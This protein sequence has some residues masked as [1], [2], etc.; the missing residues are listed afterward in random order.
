M[1][2]EV[3]VLPHYALRLVTVAVADKQN[4]SHGLIRPPKATFCRDLSSGK[5][6]HFCRKSGP[7][8]QIA[9]MDGSQMVVEN[10]KVYYHVRSFSDH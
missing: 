9:A 3:R 7:T 8:R 6:V 4:L 5:N 1:P 2:H 10:Q